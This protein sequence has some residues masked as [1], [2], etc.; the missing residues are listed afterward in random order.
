VGGDGAN[1]Y[2]A[3]DNARVLYVDQ[4]TNT[5]RDISSAEEHTPHSPLSLFVPMHSCALGDSQ[6][7]AA[8]VASLVLC[9]VPVQLFCED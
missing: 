1:S 9:L 3:S 6:H 8:F 2:F 4:Q 5:N 7:H